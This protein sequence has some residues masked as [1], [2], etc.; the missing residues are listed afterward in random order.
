MH[1]WSVGDHLTHRFNP[2]LGLGRVTAI[3]GRVLV[4]HFPHTGATL[5]LAG[6]NDALLPG[7]VGTHWRDRTL[8]ER[9]AAGDVDDTEDFLTRL[10]ILHLLATREASGL[11]SF[12]GGRVRLFPHQL[13]VAER[14][15][16]RMPVR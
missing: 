8:V 16:A 2:E 10:E 5:R 3:E 9:L 4:V 14:A 1:P 7:T 13:H 15:T 11:G 12:L 6:S